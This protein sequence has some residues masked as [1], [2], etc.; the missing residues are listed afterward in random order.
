MTV[1]AEIFS[2]G[3]EIVNG[4]TVDTNAA[5]LSTRLVEMGFT[6]NRHTAVGDRLD[7]LVGLL[8]EIAGR[9]DSCVCTGGLGPTVDDLTAEAVSKAFDL[10]LEFDEAA[11]RLIGDF[12]SLRG[13]P[14]PEANRKQAMI[15]KGAVRLDNEWGTAPGFA[16]KS[17]RCRFFFVPG[18]PYE[19]KQMFA[20]RVKPLL[21]ESFRLRPLTRVT[22]KTVGIGE[23]DIQQRMNSLTLPPGVRLGFRAG[24]NE[25]QTKLLF[26]AGFAAGEIAAVSTRVAEIIGDNVF[27]IEGLSGRTGDLVSVVGEGLKFRR[28]TL[29]L[30]ETLSQGSMASRSMGEPWLL[31]SFFASSEGRAF[32]RLGLALA[33]ESLPEK[34]AKAARALREQSGAD[35][36]LAQL[37]EGSAE[38]VA[39]EK[40]TVSLCC[41][42]ASD[43]ELAHR[44]FLIGG[45]AKRKQNQAAL[46]S[47]DFIRR[48]LQDSYPSCR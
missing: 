37:F 7:E 48:Y 40:R 28:K 26:P 5:W 33:S 21:D 17:G 43:G 47:F 36:A 11:Y 29:A 3:E 27:M 25:V 24:V 32:R 14:M 41:A 4:Q 18:V 30:L 31:E 23:S 38:D 2:Q 35:I 45:P 10:P 6:V 46:L 34:A 22:I 44:D 15:P 1:S 13:R 9:A 12:F 20:S 39:D 16:L 42:L 19:M 8:R